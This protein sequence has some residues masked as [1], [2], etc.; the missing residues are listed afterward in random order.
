MAVLTV[1][2][3]QGVES[4]TPSVQHQSARFAEFLDVQR[5]REAAIRELETRFLESSHG[6]SP[7][8]FQVEAGRVSWNDQF[9]HWTRWSLDSWP[10]QES[11][12]S[13]SNPEEA[14]QA[15]ADRTRPSISRADGTRS[16]GFTP[17]KN[18]STEWNA[19]F[20]DRLDHG[21]RK[22]S[23]NLGILFGERW[24]SRELDQLTVVS[25]HHNDNTT[26][27]SLSPMPL[28][29]GSRLSR[30][31]LVVDQNNEI[32]RLVWFKDGVVK[33]AV[34]IEEYGGTHEVELPIKGTITYYYQQTIT[35]DVQMWHVLSPTVTLDSN[36]L[37]LPPEIRAVDGRAYVLDQATNMIFAVDSAGTSV[38]RANSSTEVPTELPANTSTTGRGLGRMGAV[39]TALGV[40][41]L[42]LAVMK[43]LGT[44]RKSTE[45]DS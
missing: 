5:T 1:A 31:D 15:I 18:D 27:F 35:L 41:L 2:P 17:S 19:T 25:E 36:L 26:T 20:H 7:E 34:D 12:P 32:H 24:I 45:A 21:I 37:S 33:V 13:E 22:G 29:D 40:L 43:Q 30:T 23:L 16:V 6:D 3:V 38:V 9:E 8:P 14:W 42:A 11:Q 10:A 44:R 28:A 4:K 39:T